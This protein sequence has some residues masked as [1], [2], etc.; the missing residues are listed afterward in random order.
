ML[1]RV[2]A[3]NAVV[4]MVMLFIGITQKGAA[5]LSTSWM[6]AAIVI[7][8]AVTMAIFTGLESSRECAEC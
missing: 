5:I 6:Y 4:S 7:R 8:T 2:V 3:V 1:K